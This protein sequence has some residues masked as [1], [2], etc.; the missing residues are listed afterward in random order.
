[1]QQ[2]GRNSICHVKSI[3][4]HDAISACIAEDLSVASE[5]LRD[6]N[7]I[8]AVILTDEREACQQGRI[9]IEGLVRATNDAPDHLPPTRRY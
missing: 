6:D 1:M 2:K 3:P 8:Q 9:E 5:N 4:R 7:D